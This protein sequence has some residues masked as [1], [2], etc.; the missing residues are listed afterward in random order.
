MG[1]KPDRKKLRAEGSDHQ[2]VSPKT[3]HCGICLEV[4]LVAKY[5]GS[6]NVNQ[7]NNN[8]R[9]CQSE[10]FSIG[11][12]KL[13]SKGGVQICP[14]NPLWIHQ[15]GTVIVNCFAFK[16]KKSAQSL[17]SQSSGLKSDKPTIEPLILPPKC[18]FIA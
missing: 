18:C 8:R 14:P 2:R 7:L 10:D 9:S 15:M 17:N 3:C 16:H 4:R 12:K 11:Q 1:S 5:N 6:P 13:V